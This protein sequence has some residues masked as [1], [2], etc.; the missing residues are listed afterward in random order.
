VNFALSDL[1][2]F[3]SV[4]EYVT[5]QASVRSRIQE[6]DAAFTGRSFDVESREEWADLEAIDKRAS[7]TIAEL[8]ARTERLTRLAANGSTERYQAPSVNVR[9]QSQSH[10]PE[11]IFAIEEYRSRSSSDE[12]L[13]QA[14]RD[15]AMRAIERMRFPHPDARPDEHRADMER[16]LN[17]KDTD[18]RQ[19]ARHII[20]TASPV[21]E[22]A[23]NKLAVGSPLTA[24]EQRGTQLAMGVTTTGGYLVPAAFDPTIIPIGAWTSINAIRATSRIEQIVGSN[25]WTGLSSTAVTA[26]RAAEAAA[27]TE[28][29][30]TLGQPTIQ[31]TKVQGQI[32]YSYETGE[33]RTD[34]ASEFARLIAEAKDTEEESVFT[35]GVGDALGTATN[36]IGVQANATGTV[37]AFTP[38]ATVGDGV[39]AIADVDATY[40]ALT[41]RHRSSAIWLMSRSVLGATQG[42]ET[43]GGRLF[44]ATVGYPAVG[45]QDVPDSSGFTGLRLLGRP[46]YEAP[47]GKDTADLAG[48][49]LLTF[50][51]PSQYVIVERIGMTVEFIPNLV[52]AGGILASGQRAL[53]FHW[54]NSAKPISV[55][56]GRRLCFT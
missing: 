7:D 24:E 48:K 22:R 25:K 39:Y 43:T 3:R 10:V 44:G 21:Y 16:L 12:S 9:N 41:T 32:T 20:L 36:P 29:G 50:Y 46:V 5:Y 45:V 37:G 31:P 28:Q 51:N 4:E 19:F 35:Q 23:F 54:R 13:H 2:A 11:N 56:G 18:D 26:T 6:L 34:L 52:A 47:S 15:G 33:D 30:P 1:D 55:D 17:Y 14:Y 27:M 38:L 53:V 42:F 49:P 8:R 40:A